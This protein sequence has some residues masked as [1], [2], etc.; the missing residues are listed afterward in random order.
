[1]ALMKEEENDDQAF[2]TC[3]QTKETRPMVG[4]GEGEWRYGPKQKGRRENRKSDFPQA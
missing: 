4:G 3:Q 1:V 2:K